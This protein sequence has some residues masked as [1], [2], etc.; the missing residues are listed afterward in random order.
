MFRTINLIKSV[1][2]KEN[3]LYVIIFACAITVPYSCCPDKM[4]YIKIDADSPIPKYKQIV[5][6]FHGALE[7]KRLKK[8]QKIPS[9]N[10]LS[11]KFQLSRDTVLTAFNDL[12]TR[13]IIISKPG[14]GFYI[15]KENPLQ[16][17]KIFLLFDKLTSYKEDLYDAF[18]EELKRKG[19]VEIFFHNFNI[20]AFDTLIRESIGTYTTYVVMPIPTKSI[21]E[22]LELIPKDKLYILDRGRKMYGQ[23][24]PSVCQSFRKDVYNALVSGVKLLKKYDKLILFFSE[25][26]HAP[27]D[28]KRGFI[29]FCTEYKFEHK[30]SV[31]IDHEICKGEA[32]LVLED[33]KLVALVKQAQEHNYRLGK[34][35][36]IIS[37]NDTPLKS[38][39]ANGITVISTDF[40]AMGRNVANLILNKKKDH[41]ENPCS[42]IVRAS[43]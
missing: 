35:V 15:S 10:E 36:G 18:K 37:Y 3:K 4:D 23:D 31:K 6:S 29:Q 13:G 25:D 16:Q 33:K 21:A 2:C 42:L 43:L 38:V 41:I 28:I 20:K 11:Q 30:V 17:H 40:E 22:T 8:H 5:N 14:K 1:V 19:S 34:D 26:G 12:Q 24:H 39:V 27:M 7:D 9:I 32:Y